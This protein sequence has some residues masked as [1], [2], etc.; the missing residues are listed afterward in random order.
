MP[1]DFATI[2]SA[3]AQGLSFIERLVPLAAL[4]GPV[5]AGIGAAVGEIAALGDQVL[6]AVEGEQAILSAPDLASVQGLVAKLRAAN[7]ALAAQ[8]AAS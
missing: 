3:L 4:G 7:D 8:I 2:E 6:V 5:A 1:I